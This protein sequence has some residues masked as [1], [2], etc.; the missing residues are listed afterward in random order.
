[1]LSNRTFRAL[2][3]TPSVSK[4]CCYKLCIAL[5]PHLFVVLALFS[6]DTS[7]VMP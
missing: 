6:F 3:G 7:W 2:S 1:M 5:T 4:E